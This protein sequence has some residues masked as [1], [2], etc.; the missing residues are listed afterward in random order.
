MALEKV[1]AVIVGAGMSGAIFAAT[2]ARAGKKV[3]L[4]EQGRDWKLQDLISNEL[5]GRRI[6]RS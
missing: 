5:W 1:D 2:L 4:L 3:V 6:K